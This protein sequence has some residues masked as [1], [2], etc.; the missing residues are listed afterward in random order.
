MSKD[1]VKVSIQQYENKFSVAATDVLLNGC[2]ALISKILSTFPQ[3]KTKAQL[4]E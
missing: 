2:E 3:I 1:E 4:E